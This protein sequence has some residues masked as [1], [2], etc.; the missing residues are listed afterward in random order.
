M[1]ID[2][3][4][5]R[6]DSELANKLAAFIGIRQDLTEAKKLILAHIDPSFSHVSRA[7]YIAALIIYRRCFKDSKRAKLNIS[8]MHMIKG[9]DEYHRHWIGMADKHIAHSVNSFEQIAIGA[10]TNDVTVVGVAKLSMTKV[11]ETREATQNFAA[12]IEDIIQII[13]AP[14]IHELENSVLEEMRVRP[15][16]ELSSREILN[17]IIPSSAEASVPRT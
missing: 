15:F 17:V 13:V 8:K 2:N 14:T 7:T 4:V 5:F 16:K 6:Y 1:M 11:G 9:A 12:F 3:P 10:I